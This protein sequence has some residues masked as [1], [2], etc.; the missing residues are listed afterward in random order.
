MWT[1]PTPMVLCCRAP[2]P[3]GLG[4]RGNSRHPQVPEMDKP[5]CVDPAAREHNGVPSQQGDTEEL[6]QVGGGTC[7]PAPAPALPGRPRRRSGEQC[8]VLL[9]RS[10]L[11]DAVLVAQSREAAPTSPWA[12][13]MLL[14]SVISNWYQVTEAAGVAPVTAPPFLIAPAPW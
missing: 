1:A 9:P 8:S 6:C 11:R 10:V 3:G 5:F 7:S 13:P 2:T 12:D 14:V 4:L